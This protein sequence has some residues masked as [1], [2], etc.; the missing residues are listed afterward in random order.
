M[1]G[2]REVCVVADRHSLI[3]IMAEGAKGGGCLPGG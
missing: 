3:G 1:G 2:W